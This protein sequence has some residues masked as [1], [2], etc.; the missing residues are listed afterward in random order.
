MSIIVLVGVNI[1]A[2]RFHGLTYFGHFL[3][4]GC[5]FALYLLIIPI[6]FF[7]YIN[8]GLSEREKF[9]LPKNILDSLKVIMF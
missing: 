8:G 2:W 3:P 1:I 7:I 6:C 9:K 4:S 5:P